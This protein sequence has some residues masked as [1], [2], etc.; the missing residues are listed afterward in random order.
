MLLVYLDPMDRVEMAS[1]IYHALK[2]EVR[3]LGDLWTQSQQPIQ[4]KKRDF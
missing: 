2:E 3:N 1:P 4:V